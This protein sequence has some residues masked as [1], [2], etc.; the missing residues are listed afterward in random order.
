MAIR[1]VGVTTE[2]IS[3][4]LIIHCSN[5]LIQPIDPITPQ[6]KKI[7]AI[8]RMKKAIPHFPITLIHV[9]SFLMITP[10]NDWVA[11]FSEEKVNIPG[12]KITSP[13]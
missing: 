12:S 11:V 13:R 2:R 7:Q 9:I 10:K 6:I 8:I 1:M 5:R 3:C 4:P